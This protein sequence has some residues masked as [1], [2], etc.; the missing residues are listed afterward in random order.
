MEGTEMAEGKERSVARIGDCYF[1]EE[2]P[3]NEFT[4]ANLR[5]STALTW[6][7]TV[8]MKIAREISRWNRLQRT[9]IYVLSFI[10]VKTY[11]KVNT[12][13]QIKWKEKLSFIKC[14]HI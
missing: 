14:I 8:F 2:D 3:E 13:Q 9:V 12:E 5:I 1:P 7:N 10:N 4:S 11:E 6:E